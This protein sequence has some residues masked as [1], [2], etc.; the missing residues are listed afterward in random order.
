[1]EIY[2][3]AIIDTYLENKT[4]FKA[5]QFEGKDKM[6]GFCEL[7]YDEQAT[8][9]RDAIKEGVDAY[10]KEYTPKPE[11]NCEYS[12]AIQDPKFNI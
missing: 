4:A 1:M 11:P 9:V 10:I 7:P 5:L 3:D 6:V 2:I 12:D 8:V